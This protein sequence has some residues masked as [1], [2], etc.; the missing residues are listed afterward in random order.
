MSSVE[1]AATAATKKLASDGSSALRDFLK[2]KIL[3]KWQEHIGEKEL[4][5]YQEKIVGYL[6]FFTINNP[7]EKT[8]I[9]DIY[10]PLNVEIGHGDRFKVETLLNKSR[11]FTVVSGVAGHGKSTFLRHLMKLL[12]V[13]D[14]TKQ[15]PIFLELKYFY[16]EKIEVQICKW[17]NQC[18]LNVGINFVEKLLLDGRFTVFLDAF[19]ELNSDLMDICEERIVEFFQKYPNT[20]VIVTTRPNLQISQNSFANH[21]RMSDLNRE[22]TKEILNKICNTKSEAHNAFR[23]IYSSDFVSGAIK[24]PI[25]AVLVSLTYK[26]WQSIPETMSEFYNRVFN[27]LLSIH[28]NTKSGKRVRREINSKLEDAQILSVVNQLSYYLII[29]EKYN[30][31]KLD[32]D[33]ACIKSLSKKSFEINELK[34]VFTCLKSACNILVK[35]GF[36]EYKYIHRSFQE[37]YSAKYIDSL[38][39]NKKRIFYSKCLRDKPF[40]LKM[41]KVLEFLYELDEVYMYEYF[42]IPYLLQNK[43]ITPYGDSDISILRNINL[44]HFLE[45]I[46]G[47][48]SSSINGNIIETTYSE[49]FVYI[50]LF[51]EEFIDDVSDKIN[52]EIRK[53]DFCKVNKNLAPSNLWHDSR[54]MYPVTSIIKLCREEEQFSS[55]MLKILESEFVD[56]EDV[57]DKKL[58]NIFEKT[59]EQEDDDVSEL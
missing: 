30:F 29:E 56:A 5:K 49:L 41:I 39:H 7:D 40:R 8:Y 10:V 54:E 6:Y 31:S 37:F 20:N 12:I 59:E 55:N 33:E 43:S 46:M 11:G 44:S 35:D 17:L 58:D 1:A 27:T 42:I 15:L 14:S 48:K 36:D 19:D 52:D 57:L 22:Q 25:L 18:G 28:D 34:S 3:K 50:L 32:F 45:V 13:D 16:D 53:F 4:I 24:T 26:R 2:Q 23:A 47:S 51:G 21:Y 9:D 38:H